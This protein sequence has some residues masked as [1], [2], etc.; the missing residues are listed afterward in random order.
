MKRQREKSEVKIKK[1]MP[2]EAYEDEIY[3]SS[4]I[5]ARH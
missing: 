3:P 1:I 4:L 5:L 2:N